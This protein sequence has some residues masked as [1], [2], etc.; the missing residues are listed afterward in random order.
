MKKIGMLFISL[1]LVTTVEAKEKKDPV[2]ITV[3]GKEIPL[4]EFIYMA[5]KDNSVDLSDKKSVDY[6]VE[7]FK[8]YKLKVADAESLGVHKA[9]KFEKELGEYTRQLQESYL[10]DKAAEDS[11]MR[12]V[13]ER[14]K[15]IPG[16]KHIL[17]YLPGGEIVPKDTVEAYKKAMEAYN[18]IEN[19]ES[20]ESVG[21]S[22]T[23]DPQRKDVTYVSEAHVYPLQMLKVLEEKIFSMEPGE[24]SFPLRSMIGFHLFK[25]DRKIPNPGKVRIAHILT[26]FPSSDPTDEEVEQI[27]MKSDSIYREI[28]SGKDFAELAGQYSNDT[29]SSKRGGL[30]PYFGLGEMVDPF[31]KAAFALE[32]TGDVSEPVKTRYGFHLLKLI[33]K[34]T[35]TSFEELESQIYGFMKRSE[36]NFELYSGFDEKMKARHG[37]VFY[38][39]AYAELQRLANDY[40]P[41]DTS[42]FYRGI[43]MA[44]PLMRLDTIDYMQN[45][46][47]DYMN[48]RP[49]SAKT[50]SIDYMQEIYDLFVRDIVTEM[51]REKLGQD[52]AEYNMIVKE[53]YDGI[54]LFEISNKRVWS[55]PADEQE[56]LEAEWI[57]ELNEKYPVTINK[58]VIRKIKKYLN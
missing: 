30:L 41:T 13:Y 23:S 24:I 37:Y 45:D 22:L 11:A 1:V 6:Y 51:E 8:I 52:N 26:S 16:F 14:T 7:L 20:F 38:P 44:K 2:V 15:Y 36:R 18:R 5:R 10:S 9:S 33:D 53:Y 54:L 58:K 47:V 42:F 32:N 17:F 31:E 40:F 34:K 27:R 21:E 48:R 28:L 49:T 12:V 39:E 25:L 3:A 56:K 19:G 4:S 50:L 35:E 55:Q 46:F 43:E 29:V 57:K